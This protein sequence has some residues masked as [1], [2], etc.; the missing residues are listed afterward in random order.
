MVDDK[1][2]KIYFKTFFLLTQTFPSYYGQGLDVSLREPRK[3][4]RNGGVFLIFPQVK[5]TH[6]AHA[7]GLKRR[8]GFSHRNARY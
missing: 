1:Y 2:Y 5:G 3:I 7:L 8:C 4:L 6:M